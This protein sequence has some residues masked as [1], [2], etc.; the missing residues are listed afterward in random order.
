M[1]RPFLVR[2]R[3]MKPCRRLRRLFLGWYVRLGKKASLPSAGWPASCYQR[4]TSPHGGPRIIVYGAYI[5]VKRRK[6]RLMVFAIG[7]FVYLLVTIV[8]VQDGVYNDANLEPALVIK[9]P[10]HRRLP[11][12]FVDRVLVCR[13]CGAKFT[14]TAGEQPFYA[15]RGL[16]NDPARC[17]RC[18]NARRAGA[19]S[20]S[21]MG[22]GY[23]SYGPFASFGGRMPRQMH[24]ATRDRCGELTAVPVMPLAD[25]AG[26]R[27]DGLAVVRGAA[28]AAGAI[29]GR[30]LRR[31]VAPAAGVGTNLNIGGRLLPDDG[32]R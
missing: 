6:G 12:S 3:C 26:Y 31:C 17:Q 19:G 10:N 9:S 16:E 20:E 7:V 30:E 1:A 28:Q 15:S 25:R 8:F 18:R 32:A 11:V 23:V 4:Q 29:G 21:P 14:F 24:P 2:L 13:E 27:A 5:W 22:Q